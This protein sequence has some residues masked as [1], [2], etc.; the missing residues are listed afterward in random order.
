[1]I[2]IGSLFQFI[3]FLNMMLTFLLREKV[4]SLSAAHVA[5][6]YQCPENVYNNVSIQGRAAKLVL[7]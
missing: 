5:Y 1:M 3:L 2:S 7:T 6:Q 4:S